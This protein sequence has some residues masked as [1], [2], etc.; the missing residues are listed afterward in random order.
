MTK[1]VGLKSGNMSAY[2]SHE[3]LKDQIAQLETEIANLKKMSAGEPTLE[4]DIEAKTKKL[5]EL[6][7][8]VQ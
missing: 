6:Q 3:E 8:S 7:A 2:R 4:K 1:P 5:L